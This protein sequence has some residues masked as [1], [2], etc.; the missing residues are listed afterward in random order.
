MKK[1]VSIIAMMLCAL[2]LNVKSINANNDKP[3][4]ASD[5]GCC[6]KSECCENCKDEKCKEHCSKWN[7][8]SAE[9]QK[10]DEGKKLKE[11]CMKICKEKKCCSSDGK[12]ATC[13]DM[14]G[15]SCCHKK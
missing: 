12:T 1:Y 11:E 6:K 13:E 14:E 9:Q 3:S 7:N 10:S 15:K 2:M 8:M 4:K 5:K